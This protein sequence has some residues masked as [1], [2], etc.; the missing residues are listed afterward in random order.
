MRA[1]QSLGSQ[2]MIRRVGLLPL[3]Y[4]RQRRER[5]R[6]GFT[7][8]TG[9]VVLAALVFW[10]FMIAGEIQEAGDQLALVEATNANLQSDIDELQSFAELA[11]EV[12]KKRTALQQVMAGDVD[13][14]ALLTEVALVVPGEVWLTTLTASAGQTEGAAPVGT[15]T[16]AVRISEKRAFGR[17]QFVGKSLSFPGIAKWLIRQETVEDFS[18]VWLNS[19][20]KEAQE[21][22]A[23]ATTAAGPEVVTFDTTIELSGKIASRRFEGGALAAGRDLIEA[24]GAP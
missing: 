2:P 1:R 9:L 6:I 19:A 23:G 21:A 13:W 7:A 4:E 15:E 16:A 20:T 10:W 3:R 22:S 5:R 8:L 24:P 18:A 11:D 17:V 12:Q 14:P